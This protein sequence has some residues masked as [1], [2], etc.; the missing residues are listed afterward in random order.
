MKKPSA[1]I[2]GLII[3]SVLTI[4]GLAC[5]GSDNESTEVPNQASV[6]VSNEEFQ[7]ASA[8]NGGL[9][10]KAIEVASGDS[11]VVTLWSN[12]T[13]GYSWSEAAT[14][15]ATNLLQQTNHEYVAPETGLVGAP[16]KEVWTLK[17]LKTGTC[18][19]S[20]TYS[21]PWEGGQKNTYIFSLK[22]TVK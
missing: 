3:L 21:Q 6:E 15:I 19:V 20:M 2:I 14:I 7:A 18:E 16:G 22:V 12:Q 10:S 1:L 5:G 17:T 13:T 8:S 4:G 9:V 11:I